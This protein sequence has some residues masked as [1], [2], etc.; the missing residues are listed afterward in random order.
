[1][2]LRRYHRLALANSCQRQ[3]LDG[4]AEPQLIYNCRRDGNSGFYP[5]LRSAMHNHVTGATC[6]L[7]LPIYVAAPNSRYALC[8]DYRRLYITHQTIGY[9]GHAPADDG[10]YTLDLDSGAHRL[11]V[12]YADLRNFHP[13]ASIKD[14]PV[15][16]VQVADGT[17]PRPRLEHVQRLASAGQRRLRGLLLSA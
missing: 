10:I 6:Y 5:G 9:S 3:W 12:S 17:T 15:G 13:R 16:A 4:K 11:L 2:S 7:P 14:A 1:M 8:V